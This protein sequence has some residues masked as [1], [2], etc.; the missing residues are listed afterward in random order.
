MLNLKHVS[1]QRSESEKT[2]RPVPAHADPWVELADLVET[3]EMLLSII[4]LEVGRITQ[5]KIPWVLLTACLYALKW[6]SV[7][8]MSRTS[9]TYD[10]YSLMNVSDHQNIVNMKC[11]LYMRAFGGGED[12]TT[13]GSGFKSWKTRDLAM[14][15]GIECNWVEINIGISSKDEWF[16]CNILSCY[17]II[18]YYIL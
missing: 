3:R 7:T 8:G 17:N 13:R 16:T 5:T 6:W 11:T 4:L 1:V 10:W 18:Y 14:N 12:A 9:E 15:P 2:P